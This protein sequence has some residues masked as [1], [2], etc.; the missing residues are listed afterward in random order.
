MYRIGAVD[1]DTSHPF[2][3]DPK[4]MLTLYQ[5]AVEGQWD[6]AMKMQRKASK[7][8]ADAVSFISERG[9][10][11]CD[12]VFEKGLAVASGCLAGHQ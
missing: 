1:L 11:A 7:F 4:F 6:A 5:K 2:A 10:G 8:F 9:E 12:P 3:T